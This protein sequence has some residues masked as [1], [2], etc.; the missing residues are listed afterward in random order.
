MS[1]QVFTGFVDKSPPPRFF[2]FGSVLGGY[3]QVLGVRVGSGLGFMRK[4]VVGEYKLQIE[5]C[6]WEFVFEV[7][8]QFGNNISGKEIIFH[9]SKS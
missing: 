3:E 7:C 5:V 8:I 6:V 9:F 4:A 1:V 2:S